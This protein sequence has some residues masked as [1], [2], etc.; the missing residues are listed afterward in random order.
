MRRDAPV[1]DSRMP[2]AAHLACR[3]RAMLRDLRLRAITLPC[4]R[5]HFRH[6]APP[7]SQLQRI[8]SSFRRRCR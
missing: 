6:P 4:N 1:N 3:W 5:T 2:T 7:V 8:A